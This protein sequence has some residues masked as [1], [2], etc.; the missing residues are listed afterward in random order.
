MS[1]T[2][3]HPT[4]AVLI[5]RKPVMNYVLAAIRL[6]NQEGASEVV[7]RARGR[8]ICKAVDTVETIRNL[9]IKDLKIKSLN[10]YSE[11]VVDDQGKKRRISSIEIVVSKG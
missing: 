2:T 4:N 5:G 6:F 7:I 10:I 1:G 3:P 11:E 9:F 8:N